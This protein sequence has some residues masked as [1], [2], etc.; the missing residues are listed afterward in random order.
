MNDKAT[1]A[2]LELPG[3]DGANPLGFLAALGTLA[4]LDKAGETKARLGWR[5]SVK[6]T[7]VLESVSSQN[8]EELC[9]LLAHAL[10][11]EAV[12]SDAEE[13]RKS[14]EQEFDKAKKAVRNKRDEIKKRRLRGKEYKA[15]IEKEINP[16]EKWNHKNVRHGSER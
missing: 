16:S 3:L 6:W 15:V 1:A 9:F 14:V 2:G 12:A 11:G 8:T 7:P 4:T 10:G 13:K 5:R